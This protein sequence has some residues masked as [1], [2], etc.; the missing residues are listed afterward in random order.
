MKDLTS[1]LPEFD[2]ETCSQHAACGQVVDVVEQAVKTTVSS[3][4]SGSQ[5]SPRSD[6]VREQIKLEIKNM[7]EDEERSQAEKK[8]VQNASSE[9]CTCGGKRHHDGDETSGPMSSLHSTKECLLCQLI[10]DGAAQPIVTSAMKRLMKRAQRI[11]DQ[12]TPLIEIKETAHFELQIP[13]EVKRKL[14]CCQNFP[15]H[16]VRQILCKVI[17]G[18][19]MA[20]WFYFHTTISEDVEDFLKENCTVSIRAPR[21]VRH[22]PKL[23]MRELMSHR[24]SLSLDDFICQLEHF[25]FKI[26]PNTI[27]ARLRKFLHRILKKTCLD[28]CFIGLR[29]EIRTFYTPFEAEFALR[30]C[31]TRYNEFIDHRRGSLPGYHLHEGGVWLHNNASSE[32]EKVFRSRLQQEDSDEEEADD[33]EVEEVAGRKLDKHC[34]EG[35]H[36]QMFEEL[37]DRV[38]VRVHSLDQ[39]AYTKRGTELAKPVQAKAPRTRHANTAT[40][41]EAD[42]RRDADDAAPLKTRGVHITVQSSREERESLL[43]ESAEL[44]DRAGSPNPAVHAANLAEVTSTEPEPEPEPRP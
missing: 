13:S 30:Y 8:D 1:I 34:F 25:T 7:A 39:S 33:N 41:E 26:K 31:I 23:L 6:H 19:G 22:S 35:K 27:E 43:A 10:S 24:N 15:T 36:E 44:D 4:L 14:L 3:R 20:K 9:C 21:D 2:T 29:S 42:A 32:L 12:H 17:P 11:Y 28:R 5:A 16:R 38:L 40:K 37:I 18:M